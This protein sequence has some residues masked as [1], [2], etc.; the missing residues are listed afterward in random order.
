MIT[1]TITEL[2][3]NKDENLTLQ[4][5]VRKDEIRQTTLDRTPEEMKVMYEALKEYFE[6]K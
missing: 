6:D 2:Y 1:A 4:L 5:V 3:D